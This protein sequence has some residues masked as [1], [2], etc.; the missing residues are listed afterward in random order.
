MR[1]GKIYLTF[2]LIILLL[3]TAV[4]QP[5][6]SNLRKKWIP[7]TDSSFVID[8]FSIAPNTFIMQ[9][10]EQANYTLD[11]IDAKF[12]WIEKPAADSVFITY[13]VFPA[14]LNKKVYKYNYD[15]IRFNFLAEK[16]TRVRTS[17]SSNA[18]IDFGQ[19]ESSGSFGRAISFGNNQDAV[20]NS[21]MNLQLRGYIGDSMELTAAISD[22]NIPIQPDGN[23]QD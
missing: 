12:T 5:P 2:L 15:S 9:G 21:T 1:P 13:R 18:L 10:A 17:S 19:I 3:Q 4:A 7:V 11:E 20:L 8:S 23:T 14:R 6:L 22:N 16:P